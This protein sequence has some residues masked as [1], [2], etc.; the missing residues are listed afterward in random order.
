VETVAPV[1]IDSAPI[2]FSEY[3]S[4]TFAK[5]RRDS[6]VEQVEPPGRNPVAALSLTRRGTF[7]RDIERRGVH[8]L[9]IQ[10][11]NPAFERTNTGGAANSVPEHRAPVFAAQLVL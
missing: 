7:H 10:R 8:A 4:P 6:I 5:T 2:V 3:R 9:L 11:P 1:P